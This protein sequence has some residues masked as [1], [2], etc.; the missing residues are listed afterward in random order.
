MTI[1]LHAYNRPTPD[2]WGSFLWG[3]RV[4]GQQP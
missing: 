2:R 1:K 3:C 4:E